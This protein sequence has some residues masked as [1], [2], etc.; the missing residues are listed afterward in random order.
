MTVPNYPANHTRCELRQYI[1]RKT[2][3]AETRTDGDMRPEYD[4]SRGK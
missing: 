3:N 2:M 1:D 4:I